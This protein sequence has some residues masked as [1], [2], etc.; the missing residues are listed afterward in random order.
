VLSGFDGG[1]D[2]GTH[3]AAGNLTLLNLRTNDGGAMIQ[4]GAPIDYVAFS[5][6][7]VGGD[8]LKVTGTGGAFPAFSVTM[9]QPDDLAG[10]TPNPQ[11]AAVHVSRSSALTATWTPSASP[12]G[13]G[14]VFSLSSDAG[15]ILCLSE[16]SAGSVTV[17]AS[18]LGNFANGAKGSVVFQREATAL[19]TSTGLGI[20]EGAATIESGQ[21]LVD[22]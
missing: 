20:A 1:T 6:P 11:G 4:T 22:P 7:W 16:D 21:I 17:P 3:E 12:S 15:V 14:M 19:D 5:V 13:V 18:L 8:S 10:L 9:Q 2:G